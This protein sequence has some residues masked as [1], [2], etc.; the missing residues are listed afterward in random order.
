MPKCRFTFALCVGQAGYNQIVYKGQ[1]LSLYWI[2]AICLDFHARK[3]NLL[4]P[5]TSQHVGSIDG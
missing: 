2:P 3:A 1:S 4:A 5:G